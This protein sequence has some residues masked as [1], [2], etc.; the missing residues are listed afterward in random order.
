IIDVE[1]TFAAYS[2]KGLILT[3][4]IVVVMFVL[5]SAASALFLGNVSI[6]NLLHGDKKTEKAVRH[7]VAWCVIAVVALVGLI[8]SIII[9]GKAAIDIMR[10]A[11]NKALPQTILASLATFC[12]CIILFHIAFSRGIIGLCMRAKKLKSRGANIFT[13]RQLSGK[14]SAS[15]IMIGFLAFLITL[16]VGG[17]NTSFTLQIQSNAYLDRNY[18]FDVSA[19]VRCSDVPNITEQPSITFDDAETIVKKYSPIKKRVDFTVYTNGSNYLHGFNDG[20]ADDDV[21]IE[22]SAFNKIYG[23][24]G[25]SPVKLG[26]GFMIAKYID[27]ITWDDLSAVKLELG[28]KQLGFKG[29]CERPMVGGAVDYFWVIVPDGTT[30][31]CSPYYDGIVFSLKKT[32]YDGLALQEELMISGETEGSNGSQIEYRMTDYHLRQYARIMHYAE[33]AVFIVT[34]LYIAIVFLFLAMAMLALKTLSGISDD[35]QRY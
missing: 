26:D 21:Y 14:L 22:E 29:F 20:W 11:N 27:G 13:L 31:E 1:F 2:V 25:Y 5:S 30:A 9:F 18:P 12:V 7:P 6:Y 8:V 19:M 16:A 3:V 34:A 15:S 33:N 4:W 32:K 35:K 17:T 10:G 28:S 23:V 24:I